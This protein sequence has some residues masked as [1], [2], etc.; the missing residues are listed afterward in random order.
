MKQYAILTLFPDMFPGPLASSITGR[1]LEQKRATIQAINIRDYATD[2]HRIVDDTPYGGGSGMVMKPEPLTAAITSVRATLPSDSPIVLLT[3][4]GQPLTQALVRQLAQ[5]PGLLLVCGRYE[6]IDERMLSTFDLEISLGDYVL[7][8][9]ELGAMVVLDAVLRLLPGV[10][11]NPES[12][13]EESFQQHR[14][15]YPQYTRPPI[16]AG[17]PVPD[18]LLSGNHALIR[19]WRRKESL[20]RT[21]QRRPDLLQKYPPDPEEQKLLCEIETENRLTQEHRPSP[22]T[23]NRD[24]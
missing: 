9:G 8:G 21:L 13:A 19:R 10:L 18:A 12:L 1:A 7:S 5:A 15:E 16:F 14:L 6:G 20:R 2:K 3:P 11:G 23:P 24:S 22:N 17:I 4:Q